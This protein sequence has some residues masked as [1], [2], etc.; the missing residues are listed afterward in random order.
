MKELKDLL[1]GNKLK[2]IREILRMGRNTSKVEMLNMILKR[3]EKERKAI[4][5]EYI[6]GMW[7]DT[8]DGIVTDLLDMVEMSDI[9]FTQ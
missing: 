7:K 2:Q 6:K 8:E 1:P 9:L 3:S 5:D 4:I